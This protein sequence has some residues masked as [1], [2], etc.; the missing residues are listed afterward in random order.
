MP[1][2]RTLPSYVITQ[3]PT[4]TS[5]IIFV[6]HYFLN[7]PRNHICSKSQSVPQL[8]DNWKLLMILIVDTVRN[9]SWMILSF[10]LFFDLVTNLQLQNKPY[11][12]WNNRRMA[13]VVTSL[14]GLASSWFFSLSETDIQDWCIFSAKF[15]KHFDRATIKFIAQA[16][17]QNFQNIT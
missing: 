17:A 8:C 4:L 7:Q 15:R 12:I 5:P 11:R 6:R 10:V 9:F 14:D 2:T 16:E 13:L 1:S 3:Y